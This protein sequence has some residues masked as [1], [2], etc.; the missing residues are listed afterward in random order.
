[1]MVRWPRKRKPCNLI[2]AIQHTGQINQIQ[3]T[4]A[5]SGNEGRFF[6]KILDTVLKW[7]YSANQLENPG[8]KSRVVLV[9]LES[10]VLKSQTS[11]PR[12]NY[13]R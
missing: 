4:R 13:G 8:F 5:A 10:V 9:V 7:A 1:M 3:A 2:Y 6:S 12:K 11:Q